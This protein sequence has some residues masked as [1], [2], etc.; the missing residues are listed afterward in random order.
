MTTD[1]LGEK[2][3]LK[4]L[5]GFKP[6]TRTNCFAFTAFFTPGWLVSL[7]SQPL[8]H[9]FSAAETARS[10]L[11]EYFIPP[12]QQSPIQAGPVGHSYTGV[13]GQGCH[14]PPAKFTSDA[15]SPAQ[16]PMRFGFTGTD[17]QKH[18]SLYLQ[19]SIWLRRL[20]SQPGRRRRARRCG[21]LPPPGTTRAGNPHVPPPRGPAVLPQ[22]CGN[23]PGSGSDANTNFL[24]SE[25]ANFDNRQGLPYLPVAHRGTATLCLSPRSRGQDHGWS[26]W[27]SPPLWRGRFLPSD[28]FLKHRYSQQRPWRRTWSRDPFCTLTP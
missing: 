26:W 20:R 16:T 11:S 22:G 17:P 18:L 2:P 7:S 10:L 8:K 13:L 19:A 12:E 9:C 27:L 21:M 3:A 14:P 6:P 25:E 23:T 5:L 24:S 4:P 1:A 28:E 15:E